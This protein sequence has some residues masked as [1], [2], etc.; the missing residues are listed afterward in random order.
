MTREVSEI[1]AVKLAG[2]GLVNWLIA[3]GSR[4]A[5]RRIA[6]QLTTLYGSSPTPLEAMLAVPDWPDGTAGPAVVA[7]LIEVAFGPDSVDGLKRDAAVAALGRLG[8]VADELQTKRALE[9]VRAKGEGVPDTWAMTVAV[10]A[11]VPDAVLL[12][13]R[14]DGPDRLVLKPHARTLML[15]GVIGDPQIEHRARNALRIELVNE[16]DRDQPTRDD[17]ARLARYV[18]WLALSHIAPSSKPDFAGLIKRRSIEQLQIEIGRETDRMLR[19]LDAYHAVDTGAPSWQPALRSLETTLRRSQAQHTG[20]AR[21]FWADSWP[22]LVLK[23]V[24]VLL[25]A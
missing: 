1:T 3:D 19:L 21:K 23:K 4:V 10:S 15:A 8:R 2:D 24:T 13:L 7:E 9:L 12:P 5:S 17:P 22:D 25:G 18:A 11:Q 6:A 16:L 20:T 14:T